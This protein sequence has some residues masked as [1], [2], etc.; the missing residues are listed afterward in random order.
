MRFQKVSL[1]ISLLLL[2]HQALAVD[3]YKGVKFG[4]DIKSVMAAKWCSFQ[5]YK[6]SGIKGVQSYYCRDFKF[7]GTDTLA[8]AI[9]IEGKFERLAIN[10]NTGIDPL[11]S[12]LEKKYGK[13]SSTSTPEEGEKVMTQGGSIY[14]RYDNDTV[15]LVGTRDITKGKD[16]SQLIYSSADYNEKLTTLQSRNLDGDL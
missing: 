3:G 11:T 13:P 2:S 6:D 8:M 5:Q 4:S 7:S 1:G 14:I 9:F 16:T 12:A 15:L 10:L